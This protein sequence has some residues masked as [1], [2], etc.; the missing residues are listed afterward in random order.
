MEVAG[1]TL[2]EITLAAAQVGISAVIINVHH[3]ANGRGISEGER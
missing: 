2:L 1:R 3:F